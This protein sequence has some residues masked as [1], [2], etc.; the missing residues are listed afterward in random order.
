[1]QHALKNVFVRRVPYEEPRT[2]TPVVDADAAVGTGD[3]RKEFLSWDV[4]S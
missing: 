4:R 3:R 2:A 1:M